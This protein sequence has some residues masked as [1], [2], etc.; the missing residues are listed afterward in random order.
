M[1][2]MTGTDSGIYTFVE[3]AVK[4]STWERIKARL[5]WVDLVLISPMLI[6]FW[7]SC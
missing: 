6:A 7:L 1:K 2:T 4:V 5:H 3:P